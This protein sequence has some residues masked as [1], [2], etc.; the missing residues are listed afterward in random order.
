MF[1]I[2]LFAPNKDNLCLEM[3]CGNGTSAVGFEIFLSVNIVATT[4]LPWTFC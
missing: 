2:S 4:K 1:I 3:M